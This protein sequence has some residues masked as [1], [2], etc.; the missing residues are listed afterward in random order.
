MRP[1]CLLALT[2]AISVANSDV[3][4]AQSP[5]R[6]LRAPDDSILSESPVVNASAVLPEPDSTA[7]NFDP[8]RV[9]ELDAIHATEL[10]P[11][12]ESSWEGI[13][14]ME[15]PAAKKSGRYCLNGF[16]R[17]GFPS[18]IG[19]FALPSISSHHRVGYVG[20]GTAIGGE[21]RTVEEGTFG[22]D[23]SGIW[24]PRKTWMLW[25]HGKRHQGGA[26]QYQTD[27]PKILAKE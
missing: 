1:F 10:S 12:N 18:C 16:E 9:N 22:L 23:Y 14:G 17:A 19:R 4:D 27:G 25:S 21:R 6:K 5:I 2:V 8:V 13:R 11:A 3:L 24:F 20:G 15:N 7:S 26:G